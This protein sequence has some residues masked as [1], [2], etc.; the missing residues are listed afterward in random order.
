MQIQF[1]Q[2]STFVSSPEIAIHRIELRN[3]LTCD[4]FLQRRI[5]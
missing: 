1:I 4:N 3:M 5:C 2:T